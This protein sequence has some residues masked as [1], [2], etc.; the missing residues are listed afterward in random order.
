[1]NLSHLFCRATKS[2]SVCPPAKMAGLACDRGRV[3][4]QSIMDTTSD[5]ATESAAGVK[6]SPKEVFDRA[7]RLWGNG[8][9][10]DLN[11]I[12]FYI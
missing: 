6:E 10:R 11:H 9:H 1:M 12:M 8:I 2:V 7:S 3:Y 4:L 5:A